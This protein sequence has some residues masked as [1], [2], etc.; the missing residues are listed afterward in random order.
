MTDLNSA[1]VA[2]PRLLIRILGL[3]LGLVISL[4]GICGGLLVVSG[5]MTLADK[6]PGAAFQLT[7][8]AVGM[9]L[10]I[11][12]YRLAAVISDETL[13]FRG[14]VWT[15]RIPLSQ[16]ARVQLVRVTQEF[17]GQMPQT[18]TE[19]H[20][21]DAANRKVAVVPASLDFYQHREDFL[22]RLMERFPEQPDQ[23]ANAS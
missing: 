19:M 2:R 3:L 13:T 17:L 14:L 16:I 22:K 23:T 10:G 1:T 5:E 12:W 18:F 7:L 6:I 9:V 8:T 20:L 21:I 11:R 4:P 15:H